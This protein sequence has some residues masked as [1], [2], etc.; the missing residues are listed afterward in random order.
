[1]ARLEFIIVVGSVAH[2]EEALITGQSGLKFLTMAFRAAVEFLHVVKGDSAEKEM[3]GL[4]GVQRPDFIE[5]L[6]GG[7]EIAGD[8]QHAGK[9][10][11]GHPVAGPEP[12]GDSKR[13]RGL[14]ELALVAD[15]AA[16]QHRQIVVVGRSGQRLID[17]REGEIGLVRIQ[18][19]LDQS[20]AIG[21]IGRAGD[22]NLEVIDCFLGTIG[23]EEQLA[24]V[25][26]G[27]GVGGELVVD[28]DGV[29][30]PSGGFEGA[31]E[32]KEGIAAGRIE[33]SGLPEMRGGVV[34]A[35]VFDERAGEAKLGEGGLGIEGQSGGEGISGGF[36]IAGIELGFTEI[37]ERAEGFGLFGQSFLQ[38]R[39]GLGGLFVADEEDGEVELSLVKIRLQIEG[40]AVL[41][42][43]VGVAMEHA[44]GESEIEVS[45][46]VTGDGRNGG[47]ETLNSVRE[48]LFVEGLLAIGGGVAGETGGK[49]HKGQQRPHASIVLA[50]G[51]SIHTS[52]QATDMGDE[53]GACG[54]LEDTDMESRTSMTVGKKVGLLAAGLVAA[55]MI[56]GTATLASL[57]RIDARIDSL[58]G[59]A[60]PGMEYMGRISAGIYHF[61]GNM[62]KHIAAT[63]AAA[64]A[65]TEQE[66]DEVRRETEQSMEGYEKTATKA[67]DRANF[68]RLRGEMD[69]YYRVWENEVRPIS[70]QGTLNAQA[71]DK[72]ISEL[73][74]VFDEITRQ[75][76]LMAKWNSDAGRRMADEAS[77]TA[78]TART[79]AWILLG[80][81]LSMGIL[82]AFLIVRGLNRALRQIGEELGESSRQVASAAAQ[83]A[84]SAQALAQGASEQAASLEETS[85]SS[86]EI[87]SMARKNAEGSQSAAELMTRSQKSFGETNE[88]LEQMVRAMAEIDASSE[89]IAKII[90]IID[91]IAFQTNILALNAAVEAA[92]AGE[93]GMGFAVVADEVRNLAQRCAQAAKDTAALIDESVSRSSEGKTRMDQ[94]AA[95]IR[96]ITADSASAKA[97]VDEVSTGSGEQT[98]G[99]EQV[100]KALAQIE[101]VAQNAAASAEEGASAAEEL[102]AQSKVM[103]EV[104]VRLGELVGA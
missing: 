89:K 15:D 20:D 66:L 48:A 30:R 100:T 80:M 27:Y 45:G 5:G 47:G 28:G 60:M 44:E 84:S 72:A 33:F 12:C 13:G 63:D 35:R 46:V 17:Q 22:G 67:E 90:R 86:E 81:A 23:F 32:F 34:E 79:V 42:G 8:H 54:G 87:N 96:S 76:K 24:E 99:L 19:C 53:A 93:A 26:F 2:F 73:K 91:E 18:V 62:W 59:E 68:E 36:G 51:F 10:A 75:M 29:V 7:G 85:A 37:V 103:E 65:K 78:L 94:V 9:L 25:F 4:F 71:Y 69:Q 77:Q 64:M 11:P 57:S 92:R 14:I 1:M 6:Q 56:M 70:R 104:V 61:R 38:Q 97:M 40:F 3:A 50:G 41:G 39:E 43:A 52:R 49:Q 21:G 74:P 98:K 102:T 82:A 31:G 83:V 58:T 95:G 16:L 55:S 88:K 101:R